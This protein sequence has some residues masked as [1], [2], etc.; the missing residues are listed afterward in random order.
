MPRKKVSPLF[1]KPI[2]VLLHL[3][4]ADWPE[5][6]RRRFAEA[7]YQPHDMFADTA[8][9]THLRSATKDAIHFSYRRWMGWIRSSHP[10]LMD[11]PP[12][13]RVTP[14]L[15]KDYVA[16]LRESCNERSV[17]TQIAKLHD[18]FR[19]MYPER[20]WAWLREMTTRLERGIPK[21]GRKPILL[22]S[23]VLIDR[24]LARLDAVD[25]DYENCHPDTTG[26]DIQYLA[27]RYRDGLLVALAGFQ[28]LRRRNLT[29]LVI[30][31]TLLRGTSGWLISMPGEQV[32]NGEPID[33]ELPVWIS[34]RVDRYLEVYRPLIYRSATHQ[35][36]WA[37]AKGVPA[38]GVAL[39]LAF[40]KETYK[41][42]GVHLT[43]HDTRRIA[44][45]TW[46]IHDPVNFAGAKDLLADR[47]DRV[48]AENYNLASGIE[49]SRR[50]ALIR[51]RLMHEELDPA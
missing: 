42:L 18:A 12:E 50:M 28:P 1:P 33:A 38:G 43:L 17:A 23:Q 5:G 45:T 14:A 21:R 39:Y 2:R 40:Q 27:L 35:G 32:K 20:D 46:A 10:D 7:F 25:A 22:T 15:L 41:A 3:P 34:E 4:E 26:K 11:A 31:S 29:E 13:F 51:E 47:T 49:A 36:L 19:Y 8:S 24:S 6:D 16:H 9:G 30:G 44:A 48:I 37:T